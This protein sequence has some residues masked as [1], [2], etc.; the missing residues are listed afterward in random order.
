MCFVQQTTSNLLPRG[1]NPFYLAQSRIQEG[2]KAPIYCVAFNFYN[3][4]LVGDLLASAGSNRVSA[5]SPSRSRLLESLF[6]SHIIFV[7][8]FDIDLC[9]T[10]CLSTYG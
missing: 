2:H 10:T 6:D 4:E 1:C 9:I 5:Q 8:N 7:S 3:R